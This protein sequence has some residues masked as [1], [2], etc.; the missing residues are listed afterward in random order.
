MDKLLIVCD[1]CNYNSR[2]SLC[3]T[4]AMI[5]ESGAYSREVVPP[6]SGKC[7][8]RLSRYYCSQP[9]RNHDCQLRSRPPTFWKVWVLSIQLLS[10]PAFRKPELSIKRSSPHLLES[11][12]LVYPVI[13]APSLSETMTVSQELVPPPSG[14]CES[15]GSNY[16]SKPSWAFQE[17][18]NC[19]SCSG[20]PWL[21][22][23]FLVI[24][25]IC[26]KLCTHI[27]CVS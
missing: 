9:F 25:D 6:P 10:L 22:R 5:E 26:T 15:R 20:L 11:V 1:S 17:F 18:I 21:S 16:R 2:H 14:K 13:I 19:G 8:S 7:E 27:L 24:V 3:R 23:K 4:R 12:S